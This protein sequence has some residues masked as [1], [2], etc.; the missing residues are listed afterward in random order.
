[1][2][3]EQYHDLRIDYQTCGHDLVLR[4]DARAGDTVR[5]SVAGQEWRATM[6]SECLAGTIVGYIS[7]HHG[8]VVWLRE[9]CK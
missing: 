3:T 5:T 9:R 7:P 2:A 1:M 4:E 6:T 8:G